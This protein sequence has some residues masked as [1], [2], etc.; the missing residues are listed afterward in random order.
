MFL[1]RKRVAEVLKDGV[2]FWER[3]I[4]GKR[5]SLKM[6]GPLIFWKQKQI[7]IRSSGIRGLKK[8]CFLSPTEISKNNYAWLQIIETGN[9]NERE[10]EKIVVENA[11]V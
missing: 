7:K 10:M 8:D 5:K 11:H 2:E 6:L 1:T 3:E 9:C 4:E